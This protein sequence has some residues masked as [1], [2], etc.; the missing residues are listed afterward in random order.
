MLCTCGL[1]KMLKQLHLISC[2]SVWAMLGALLRWS[3]NVT[4]GACSLGV[5]CLMDTQTTMPKSSASEYRCCTLFKRSFHSVFLR[6]SKLASNVTVPLFSRWMSSPAHAMPS[7]RG[8]GSMNT[9]FHLNDN[10]RNMYVHGV[11]SPAQLM[12]DGLCTSPLS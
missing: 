8:Q 10:P 5:D 12:L 4:L 1:S 2:I 11:T 3:L 7:Y 6:L 9:T